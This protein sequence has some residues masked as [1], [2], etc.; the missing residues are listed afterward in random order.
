MRIVA[1]RFSRT[2][3]VAALLASGVGLMAWGVSAQFGPP[4]G[5][6]VTGLLLLWAGARASGDLR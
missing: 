4:V 5:A 1:W 3:G 6:I 2:S